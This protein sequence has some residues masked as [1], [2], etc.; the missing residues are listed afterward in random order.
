MSAQD[1]VARFAVVGADPR[2]SRCGAL[3]SRRWAI[4]DVYEA[5]TS[6]RAVRG[7]TDQ[8][9][10]REVLERVLSAAAWSPSGSNLQDIGAMNAL[11]AKGD[12]KGTYP[13][14]PRS[15]GDARRGQRTAAGGRAAPGVRP[16]GAV[17][18]PEAARRRPGPPWRASKPSLPRP[19]GGNSLPSRPRGRHPGPETGM[20]PVHLGN[21]G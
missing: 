9:V 14:Y 12:G 13:T 2:P 20:G 11:F 21:V 7:F 15:E 1:L 6:R 18:R 19:E 17:V 4:M 5:V 16:Q 8:H 10:P 3:A